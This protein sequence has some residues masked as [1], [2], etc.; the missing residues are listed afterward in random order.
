M[1]EPRWE[2]WCSAQELI[3][4]LSEAASS[5]AESTTFPTRAKAGHGGLITSTLVA[6]S[7]AHAACLT[8]AAL[9]TC[10]MG[11]KKAEKLSHA[12]ALMGW[13]TGEPSLTRHISG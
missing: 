4:T 12:D 6:G 10:S 13:R 3:R 9:V 11:A 1:N 7:R 5:V 2:N 8:R